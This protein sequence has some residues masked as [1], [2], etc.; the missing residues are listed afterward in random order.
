MN[1]NARND[2]INIC[3]GTISGA[4]VA[5]MAN[6]SRYNSSPFVPFSR[7][8]LAIWFVFL[9]FCLSIV[10]GLWL[11]GW[12]VYIFIFLI[13]INVAISRHFIIKKI[14]RFKEG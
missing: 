8:S 14:I 10:F 2:V 12:F 6:C 13:I 3:S 1:F 7:R 9:S 4:I 5:A 11:V